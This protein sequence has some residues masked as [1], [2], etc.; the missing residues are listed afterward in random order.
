MNPNRRISILERLL[1]RYY[2]ELGNL[3]PGIQQITY[4]NGATATVTLTDGESFTVEVS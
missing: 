4:T 1:S 2:D 3:M